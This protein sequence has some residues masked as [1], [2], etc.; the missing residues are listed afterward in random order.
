MKRPSEI[1]TLL[2]IIDQA[3]DH[4]SWHG[5][6]M[7]GSLRGITSAGALWRPA[8]GRHNIWEIVLHTAYYKY[9]I[10]RRIRGEKR[11]SFPLKGSDWIVPEKATEAAWKRDLKLLAETHRSMREAIAELKVSDLK[12]KAS[13]SKDDNL[14]LV[15]GT[16]AH[17][18]YHAGQ[19]QLLKRLGARGKGS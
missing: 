5:T 15:T 16:A 7:K 9:I 11:G 17:D 12:K 2:G 8:P 13:G 1:Q 10:R 18:L 4:R 6:N 19:I 3:F 14:Y